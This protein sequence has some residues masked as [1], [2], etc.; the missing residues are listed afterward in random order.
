MTQTIIRGYKALLDE[1]NAQI[2][3]MSVE[4]VIKAA[5][6]PEVVIVDIRDPREI[7][8]EGKIPGSFYT[9]RGNE[10]SSVGAATAMGKRP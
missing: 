9:G 10:A 1:A 7:E 2:E 5:Q 8:R 3:T 4:D 6:S